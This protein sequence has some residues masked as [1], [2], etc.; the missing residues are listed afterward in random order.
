MS[1]LLKRQRLLISVMGERPILT[2]Y[3]LVYILLFNDIQFEF[4][5]YADKHH[6][7]R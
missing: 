4:L 3:T 2:G 6:T 5:K 7:Y 1:V